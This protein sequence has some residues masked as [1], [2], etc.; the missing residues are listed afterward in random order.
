MD[1][2]SPAKSVDKEL[3]L[4]P[5]NSHKRQISLTVHDEDEEPDLERTQG[6][7]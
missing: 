1:T 2:D 3:T 6:S 4:P 7:K 5:I